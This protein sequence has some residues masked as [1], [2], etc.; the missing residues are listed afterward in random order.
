[1]LANITAIEK[2][3]MGKERCH[4]ATLRS[5]LNIYDDGCTCERTCGGHIDSTRVRSRHSRISIRIV[6]TEDTKKRGAYK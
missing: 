6:T 4:T 2:R 5:K 3:V 1:M